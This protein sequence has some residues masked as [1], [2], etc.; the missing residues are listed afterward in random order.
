MLKILFN[1]QIK[2]TQCGFKL[3]KSK[4]AKKIFNEIHDNGF[5]HDVEVVLIATKYGYEIKELPV[6]WIHKNNSKLNLFKDP[7]KM[8]LKLINLKLRY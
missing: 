3:Y 5:V 6:K 2:D 4:I 7:L 1:I 8:F